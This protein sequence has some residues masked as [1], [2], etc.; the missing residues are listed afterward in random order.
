MEQTSELET[1]QLQWDA[2]MQILR[3]VVTVATDHIQALTDAIL[4]F[5]KSFTRK[6]FYVRL[7]IVGIPNWLADFISRK[8]PWRW[9]PIDWIYDRA[10][11]IG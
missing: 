5:V 11:W 1:W 7:I 10:F 9:M 3:E 8:L 4:E 2:T 6:L